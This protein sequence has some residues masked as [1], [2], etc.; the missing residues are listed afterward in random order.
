V[1]QDAEIQYYIMGALSAISSRESQ[2]PRC[3]KVSFDAIS[4]LA[5]S[6]NAVIWETIANFYQK[7]GFCETSVPHVEEDD[8]SVVHISG[9]IFRRR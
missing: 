2:P 6:W 7:A 1:Q 9:E 8:Y 4:M 3:Y 5:A